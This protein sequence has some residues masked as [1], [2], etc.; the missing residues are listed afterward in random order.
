MYYTKSEAPMFNNDVAIR[1]ET[2]A[3]RYSRLGNSSCM[4][5]TM[6]GDFQDRL[7]PVIRTSRFL[8]NPRRTYLLN[9]L[10][11]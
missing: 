5:G 9:E 4:A 10:G 2:H 11:L 1:V 3:I 6:P 8:S 7:V